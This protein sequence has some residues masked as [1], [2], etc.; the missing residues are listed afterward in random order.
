MGYNRAKDIIDRLDIMSIAN[1][2][3]P[4]SYVT[5]AASIPTI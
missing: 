5:I 3:V 4:E 2:L 1:R